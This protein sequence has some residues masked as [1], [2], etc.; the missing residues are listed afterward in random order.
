MKL[1]DKILDVLEAEDDQ[2]TFD[3]DFYE[4]IN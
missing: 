2:Y 3:L 4:Y 1:K